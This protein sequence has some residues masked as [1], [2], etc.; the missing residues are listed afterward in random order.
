MLWKYLDEDKSGRV[1]MQE[2]HKGAELRLRQTLRSKEGDVKG[3][4]AGTEYLMKRLFS[5]EELGIEDFKN[6]DPRTVREKLVSRICDKCGG[7]L[8]SKKSSFTMLDMI[9]L[10]WPCATLNTIKVMT[11]WTEE[12]IEECKQHRVE[13]PPVLD[14]EQYDGL[15]SI[16][17]HYDQEYKSTGELHFDYLVDVGLIYQDQIHKW[18]EDWDADG[19][20]MLDLEEF[21]DMMCPAGYRATKKSVVGSLEDGRRVRYDHWIDGWRAE[22]LEDISFEG[23]SLSRQSS[24]ESEHWA[25]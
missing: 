1:D 14:E 7:L 24:G 16:F 17:K 25:P 9:R 5:P 12:I 18:R 3:H 6:L 2:F 20:G 21:C 11:D 19:N 13:P 4:S 15:C 10:L 23:Q 8:F 22:Q